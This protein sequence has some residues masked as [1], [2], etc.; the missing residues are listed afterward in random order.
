LLCCFCVL[1]VAGQRIGPRA[2][3]MKRPLEYVGA[4]PVWGWGPLRPPSSSKRA[5]GIVVQLSIP[6]AT[7]KQAND[8]NRHHG[9]GVFNGELVGPRKSRGPLAEPGKAGWNLVP[10]VEVARHATGCDAVSPSE[11]PLHQGA[12]LVQHC[13]QDKRRK[14]HARCRTTVP[15][16]RLNGRRRGSRTPFVVGSPPLDGVVPRGLCDRC[17]FFF[18]PV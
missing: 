15:P 2:S 9:D 18:S 14:N 5:T 10:D 17:F 3:S 4:G 11:V 1:S 16:A 12:N 6:A 8:R 13:L 7:P